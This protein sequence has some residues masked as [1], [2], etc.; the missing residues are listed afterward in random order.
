MESSSLRSA[1]AGDGDGDSVGT[2]SA[3][4]GDGDGV[5]TASDGRGDCSSA[6]TAVTSEAGGEGE[7]SG[8]AGAP[9]PPGQLPESCGVDGGVRNSSSSP[10]ATAASPLADAC[11]VGGSGA[12]IRWYMYEPTKGYSFVEVEISKGATSTALPQP[13]K[14]IGSGLADLAGGPRHRVQVG[15]ERARALSL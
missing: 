3:G 8:A 15:A 2:A 9:A 5:G 12:S 14:Q 11:P 10:A 4:D 13:P 7:G 1:S 6:V